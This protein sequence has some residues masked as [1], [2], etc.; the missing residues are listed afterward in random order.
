MSGSVRPRRGPKQI[1][2]RT[3]TQ[4]KPIRRHKSWR[5]G[6][7]N[8]KGMVIGAVCVDRGWKGGDQELGGGVELM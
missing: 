4:K 2:A 7:P 5:C 3:N 6:K 8:G 1:T